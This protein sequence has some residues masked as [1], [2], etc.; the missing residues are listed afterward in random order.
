MK[1][2]YSEIYDHTLKKVS[3]KKL[4]I[5]ACY[6]INTS[7]SRIVEG[8]CSDEMTVFITPFYVVFLCCQAGVPRTG[9]K[10]VVS[11]MFNNRRVYLAPNNNWK[12]YDPT[13]S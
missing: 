2:G 11:F 7:N 3:R 5:V 9:Y 6:S 4:C 10:G 12:G 1:D 8:I 13:W